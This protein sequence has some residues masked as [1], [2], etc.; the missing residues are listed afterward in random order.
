M[1]KK[2]NS[3]ET[4]NRKLIFIRH[5][6]A[7]EYYAEISDYERSL[8]VK[9]KIYSRQMAEILKARGEKPERLSAARPSVHLR[10]R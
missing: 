6:K 4:K 2:N 10:R 8:T 9:G 1:V 7:E 5:S 3:E